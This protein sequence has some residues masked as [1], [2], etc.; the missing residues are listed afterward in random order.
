MTI[1]AKSLLG[2]ALLIALIAAAASSVSANR[3]SFSN[4]QSTRAWRAT[5]DRLSMSNSE[6]T[7]TCVLTLEGS[8]HSSTFT[9][10]RA[11]LVGYVTDTRI[12]CTA[13]SMTVLRTNLPWHLRYEAFT[14]TLPTIASL[15]LAIVGLELSIRESFIKCLV[16]STEANPLSE[17]LTREAGGIV[18]SAELSGRFASGA[19]C[20][21]IEF[22]FE[23]RSNSFGTP[24]PPPPPPTTITLTLI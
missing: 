19:E 3:L 23:G 21:G 20:S 17:T 13:L 6:I 14:G 9:K 11:A 5:W 15:R 10:T 2:G 4:S 12:S 7:H 1:Y 18:T 16:R 8:F 24:P 22:G